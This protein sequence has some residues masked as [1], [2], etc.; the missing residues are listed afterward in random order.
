MQ[1]RRF[2]FFD[3]DIISENVESILSG[4]VTAAIADGGSLLF[5]DD[6][7]VIA[8]TDRSFNLSW[9]QK[10][11]RGSIKGVAYIFDSLGHRKQFVIALG[12][13]TPKTTADSAISTTGIE[14]GV[15]GLQYIIKIFSVTDL[16]RPIH[17]IHA[18]PN[19]AASDTVTAFSAFSDGTRI[20]VGFSSGTVL[21][22]TG[23]FLKEGALG[24]QQVPIVLLPSHE[25]TVC[26]LHFCE[27]P[28]SV[29]IS[30]SG[31]MSTSTRGNSNNTQTLEKQIRLFVV[32]DTESNKSTNPF[33]PEVQSQSIGGGSNIGGGI[34]VFSIMPP[35]VPIVNQSQSQSRYNATVLD[36]RGVT[37]GCSALVT[38]TCELVVGRSEGLFSFSVEDRGGAAGIEGD[39]E[40]VCAMNRYVL[41][42]GQEERAQRS[43]ITAYDL[44]NK[45][46]GLSHPLGPGE[47]V[48]FLLRD[49]GVAFVL[50]TAGNLIRLK[51][52]DT[53]I[54]LRKSLFPLALTVAAEEQSD[55]AE[56]MKLY[57][58]GEFSAAMAQYRLTAGVLLPSAVIR[59]YL[60]SQLISELVSYL[61]TLLKKSVADEE[62]VSLLLGCY[63]KTRDVAKLEQFVCAEEKQSEERHGSSSSSSTSGGAGSG[64]TGGVR[65]KK[66]PFHNFSSTT[67]TSSS[68]TVHPDFSL[69]TVMTILLESGFRDFALRLAVAKGDHRSFLTIQLSGV[70][71]DVEA[72]ICYFTGLSVSLDNEQMMELLKIHGRKLLRL[73]GEAVTTLLARLCVG[74]PP[75]LPQLPSQSSSMSMS[76]SQDRKSVTR[77]KLSVTAVMKLEF[78]EQILELGGSTALPAAAANT[79][80]EL[81]LSDYSVLK[82]E[83]EQEEI[84]SSS[85]SS[86]SSHRRHPHH[87]KEGSGAEKGVYKTTPETEVEA[88][89]PS[90]QSRL[91]QTKARILGLLDDSYLTYDPVL[92]LL[93]TTVFGFEEGEIFL[94]DRQQ[95]V[96]STE[97]VLKK[98]LQNNS[99][100]DSYNDSEAFQLLRR[101]GDRNPDL[102]C[103]ALSHFLERDRTRR[104]RLP[105]K[106]NSSNITKDYKATDED[107]DRWTSVDRLLQ[108]LTERWQL[109]S[110]TAQSPSPSYVCTV[111]SVLSSHP[112][113]PLRLASPFIKTTIMGKSGSLNLLEDNVRQLRGVVTSLHAS[114]MEKRKR[115]AGARQQQQQH[116]SS[117][118]GE[119]ES[120]DGG[121][122]RD[123][124]E[125]SEGRDRD[126][127]DDE[128]MDVEVQVE[129]NRD[130]ERLEQQQRRK[131]EGIRK[132][133]AD[134]AADHET[135]FADLENSSDGFV[136]AASFFGK[137]LI[138]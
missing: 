68:P 11:F 102:F 8:M 7:G 71:P 77:L 58:K 82:S 120:K 12:D 90:L 31:S 10:I 115:A 49:G 13:D 29:S 9:K 72:A 52:K 45:L 136:T 32:L 125:W 27:L 96:Q 126:L 4:K 76:V 103:V 131:W 89:G 79:L 25:Y 61:E 2:A 6:N 130:Q 55:P 94:L 113:L 26:G 48:R 56:V 33:E 36:E 46:I 22:F 83:L 67:S 75:P 3:K 24:R 1:W 109:D 128:E 99:D 124:G 107:I 21:L 51:E 81:H 17:A 47:R 54:L 35:P 34:L 105:T 18:N 123:D 59:R 60:D 42:S 39:K 40:C 100:N 43:T 74:K 88:I 91:E 106:R 104:G 118:K 70:T 57:K 62:H 137:V 19:C 93:N 14:G 122:S 95:N 138:T 117:S 98:H 133:Q 30:G 53:A 38:E 129:I 119:R 110:S 112:E 69:S 15:T 134:R 97:M 73:G 135:F 87:T 86:S 50:T 101:E 66:D 5:G 84:S 63:A 92:A 111:V 121:L 28:L 41:V 44:R 64:A 116:S 132:A 78:L 80:L 20:A 85:T 114:E 16:T 65:G 23:S 108:M 127:D 37:P